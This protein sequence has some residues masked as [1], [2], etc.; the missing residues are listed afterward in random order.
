MTN[1]IGPGKWPYDSGTDIPFG[2]DGQ[3]RLATRANMVS[4]AGIGYAPD[5]ATRDLLVTN[6]DA[7]PGMHVLV[8]T[9]TIGTPT[10]YEYVGSGVWN[11]IWCQTYPACR[12]TKSSAQSTGTA[13]TSAAVLWNVESYDNLSMHSTSSNTSRITVPTGLGGFYTVKAT[14]RYNHAA[15]QVFAQFAVNGTALPET[16]FYVTCATGS[17][18]STPIAADLILNAGDYVEVLMA[19][20]DTNTVALVVGGCSFSLAFIH[21]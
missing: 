9:T 13:G 8:A 12:L 19:S 18:A 20:A 1:F 2:P 14:L 4:G 6:G 7:F 10:V 15:A 5:I 16:A 17:G 11:V 3:Q 21:G